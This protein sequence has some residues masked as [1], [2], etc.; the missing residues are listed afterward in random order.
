MTGIK[1]LIHWEQ[2][3]GQLSNEHRETF[4][5]RT[6]I[7]RMARYPESLVIEAIERHKL[8]RDALNWLERGRL[9]D[10]LKPMRRNFT[11]YRFSKSKR[12]FQVWRES[13]VRFGVSQSDGLR[14]RDGS[15]IPPVDGD[16]HRRIGPTVNYEDDA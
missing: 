14:R 7:R 15:T 12:S 13:S 6:E 4:L 5:R 2:K 8:L 16:L 1:M 11:E 3:H 9:D 10:H